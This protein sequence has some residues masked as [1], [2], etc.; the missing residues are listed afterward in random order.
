MIVRPAQ[1]TDVHGIVLVWQ[2]AFAEKVKVGTIV[3]KINVPAYGLLVA[4]EAGVI[5]GFLMLG[6]GKKNH[7]HY[8]A[9]HPIDAPK[10]T[11][12]LLMREAEAEVRARGGTRLQLAVRRA[13]AKAIRFY[14][15]TGYRVL[16]ERPA[17]FTMIKDLEPQP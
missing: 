4:E 8:I 10:G 14:E 1:L 3:S 5:H 2:A 17:G 7:V 16:E 11:G 12:Q 9:S 6:V 15:K 13:N